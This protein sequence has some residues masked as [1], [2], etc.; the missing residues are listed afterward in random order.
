MAKAGAGGV[1]ALTPEGVSMPMVFTAIA[2]CFASSV[3]ARGERLNAE[4]CQHDRESGSCRCHR[5]GAS[6]R[7]DVMSTNLLVPSRIAPLR[8]SRDPG[9]CVVARKR[10]SEEKVWC[11]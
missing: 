9:L 2:L 8:V 11:I 6:S 1:S 10:V 7:S 3:S 4:G 5:G